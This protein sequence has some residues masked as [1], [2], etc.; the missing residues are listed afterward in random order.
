M[1]HAN[2]AD[3]PLAPFEAVWAQVLTL[4]PAAR[5]MFALACAERLVR[6]AGRADE[7]RATLEAGWA[8]AGGGSADLA[9]LR[10]ELDVR[11][12]LDDD[13]LAATY[14]ALGAATGSAED[15]RAAASRAMD[16]AFEL[17]PYGPDE[18]T[19]HPLADDAASP[20]VQAE[21]AWQ[22]AAAAKLVAD[23]PTDAV[24]VWLRQ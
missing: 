7:L 5:A 15:C 9:P 2:S 13:D 21:L 23:G 18:T 19:F 1:S 3:G 22:Q 10:S 6:A 16:A 24:A 4:S 20:P 11:E 8:V 12:D 17:V 14:Y